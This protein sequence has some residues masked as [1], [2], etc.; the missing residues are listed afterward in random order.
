VRRPRWSFRWRWP[1]GG[2]QLREWAGGWVCE[3]EKERG[4]VGG[5][6]GVSK[7]VGERERYRQ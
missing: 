5:R 4:K 1:G 7:G 2:G 6:K 3:R